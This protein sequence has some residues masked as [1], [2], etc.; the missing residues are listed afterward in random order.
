MHP[1]E[2]QLFAP[3]VA[4]VAEDFEI[5]HVAIPLRAGRWFKGSILLGN[6]SDC[7]EC[8]WWIELWWYGIN[9]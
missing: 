9:F 6:W 7:C 4:I 1:G 3:C 2:F 5:M 8:I